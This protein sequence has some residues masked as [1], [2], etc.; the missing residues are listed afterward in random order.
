MRRPLLAI[1]I[2]VLV[3]ASLGVAALVSGDRPSGQDRRLARGRGL[4]D[5]EDYL[6]A[7]DIF[8]QTIADDPNNAAARTLTGIAHLRLHL[9]GSAVGHFE[10]ASG[11]EP[12]RADP[13][14]GLAHAHLA[15]GN[16]AESIASSLEA[17]RIDPRAVEAWDVMAQAYWQDK[18]LLR[19]RSRGAEGPKP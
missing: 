18:K 8:E 17:T 5:G 9:Y 6:R 1:I 10:L 7:L 14:I 2:P 13:W 4:L 12:S 3:I 15:L 11:L 16:V 19:C